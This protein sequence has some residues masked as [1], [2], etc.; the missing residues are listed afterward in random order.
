MSIKNSW[1]IIEGDSESE[2]LRC[3][4]RGTDHAENDRIVKDGKCEV[5]CPVCKSTHLY[6]IETK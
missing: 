6:L 3:H 4:Y 5:F 2:C 1:V